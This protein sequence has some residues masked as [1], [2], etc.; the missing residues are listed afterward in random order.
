LL[1]SRSTWGLTFN[2]ATTAIALLDSYGVVEF[3][4]EGKDSSVR[5]AKDMQ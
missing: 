1:T 5:V 3:M 4:G 2:Q